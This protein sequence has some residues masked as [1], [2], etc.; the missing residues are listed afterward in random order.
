MPTKI[1]NIYPTKITRYTVV[2]PD[3]VLGVV[4]QIKLDYI[5]VID[6]S[7]RWMRPITDLE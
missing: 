7:D 3:D 2:Q 4:W 5:I 1:T 6:H